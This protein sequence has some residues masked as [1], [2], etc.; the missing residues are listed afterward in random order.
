[1]SELKMEIDVQLLVDW[2]GA[3]GAKAALRE[4]KKC[5]LQTLTD[6]ASRSGI[7]LGKKA[8][9]KELIDEIIRVASQRIHKP[10]QELY[11]MDAAQL[12][13]YFESVEAEPQ[14][15]LE[16]VKQLELDPGR[17]GLR[18]LVKYVAREISETGRFMRI[19]STQSPHGN[20]RGEDPQNEKT[21]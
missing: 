19:A 12:V 20:S 6:I 11:Q 2:L 13:E 14:E 10:L 5:S 16:L 3:Q 7:E 4:S 18:N 17:D 9:R 21:N 15:L 1:M 8:T